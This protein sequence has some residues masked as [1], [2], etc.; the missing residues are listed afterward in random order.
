MKLKLSILTI[1]LFLNITNGVG[2]S[3]GDYCLG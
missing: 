1:T 2:A 3:E